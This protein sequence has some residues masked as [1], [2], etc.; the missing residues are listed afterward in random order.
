MA[1]T[2]MLVRESPAAP[3]EVLMVR[4][5]AHSAF[6]PD[7]YVFP[8]GAVD[9]DDYKEVSEVAGLDERHIARLF[10]IQSTRL[11]ALSG[12]GDT[13]FADRRALLVAALRELF[14]EAGILFGAQTAHHP[15]ALHEVRTAL[16]EGAI[17]FG[18][19]LRELGTTLRADG[20]ELFSEWITPP[21]EGR[22][23][24]AHFFVAPADA[25]HAVADRI[26]T[27]DAVWISPGR[28]LEGCARGSHTMVYPT[29]KHMER[30]SQFNGIDELLEFAKTKPIL[31]IMPNTTR[32]GGFALPA[33]LELAW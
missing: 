16:Q 4:R 33:E 14:E 11:L 12:V 22:R 24:D 15:A 23:F 9:M 32:A 25:Q 10:R 8:G 31:R 3:F 19:A 20:L 18:Q 13:S 29:I 7:A 2:V 6:A 28:A 17:T 27:H 21:S 30:L 5:N 1:A 26:E